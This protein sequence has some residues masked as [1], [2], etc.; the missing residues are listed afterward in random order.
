[1]DNQELGVCHRTHGGRPRFTVNQRHLAEE[2]PALQEAENSLATVDTSHIDLH[3]ARS[4][5]VQGLHG[6]VAFQHHGLVAIEVLRDD[7]VG[8]HPELFFVQFR[9]EFYTLQ[10]SYNVSVH[11]L[12]PSDF[13]LQI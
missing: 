7:Q 5:E 3:G 8:K 4:D 12:I 6:V 2:V 13:L 1:M 10:Q 11:F 9:E